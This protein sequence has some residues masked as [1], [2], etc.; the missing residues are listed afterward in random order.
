MIFVRKLSPEEESLLRQAVRCA[1]S[2]VSRRRAEIVL[3]S[4]EGLTAPQ[5]ARRFHC[6]V[7]HVRDVIHLFNLRGLE[8]LRPRYRGG[9][10]RT[11]GPE[12]RAKLVQLALTS[13]QA[14]GF[15]HARWSLSRL[16]QA[17]IQLGIVPAIS[18]ETIRLVLEEAGVRYRVQKA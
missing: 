7:D 14:A 18:K 1:V 5:I 8:A 3:A 15:P 11:F 9:R 13:P 12:E 17:A 6:A 2:A 16:R 10:P 4:A